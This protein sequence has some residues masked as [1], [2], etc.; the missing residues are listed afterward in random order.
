VNDPANSKLPR[1]GGI[2]AALVLRRR[3]SGAY[4]YLVTPAAPRVGNLD[5]FLP[6]VLQAGVDM[7][8]LREKNAE[9]GPLLRWCE[10]VRR[11]TTEF[12]ALFIVNDRVDVAIAAGADGVH[13]GQDDLPVTEARS[14]LGEVPLIG[15][16]THSESQLVDAMTSGADY[17]AVG[18]VY[19]TPTKPGRAAVGLDL[20]GFAA[21]RATLPVF[22]IGGINPANL[23]RVVEAGATRV[24]VV[25]SLT[26]SDDAALAAGRMSAVLRH[27][28]F[29]EKPQA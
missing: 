15:L 9:A 16:S 29:P 8:Q 12:G 6:R 28:P 5:E 13:L 21:D 3:L 27:L 23:T 24:S 19:S 22:A 26:E 2:D 10:V 20:V 18:P 25:R 1:I 14:Q 11:R 7:V 17:A 4:L